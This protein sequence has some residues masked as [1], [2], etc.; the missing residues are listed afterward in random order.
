ML[1]DQDIKGFTLLELLV[2][3]AIVSIVTAI[4]LPNFNSWK[5]EREV[6]VGAEKIAQVLSGVNAQTKRGT[7]PYVQ[8]HI[9]ANTSISGVAGNYPGTV[10][11]GRGMT[12]TNLSKKLNSGKFP[13]C[14]TNLRTVAG[15][16]EAEPTYEYK[17]KNDTQI[18]LFVVLNKNFEFNENL[19]SKIIDEIKINL[20]YKHIPSQ[21]Y[22]IN[23]IPKTRSGKIVEILIK[24]LING[25]SIE[26]EE[27]LANPECLKEFELV[28]KNLKNNYA[29]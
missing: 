3:I 7:F 28:Y 22:A 15:S 4:G 16:W 19:R 2:V 6:R 18:I 25:E 13:D 9:N 20:S 29:E 24:K 21:I 17:L 8:M 10:V 12:R 26:N 23:E 5:T 27:S 1:Q 14:D 11:L